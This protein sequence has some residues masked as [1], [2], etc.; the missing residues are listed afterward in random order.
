MTVD[1]IATDMKGSYE[2][3]CYETNNEKAPKINFVEIFGVKEEIWNAQIFAE[4]SRDH[5]KQD[6]P[7]KNKYYV[8]FQIVQ[9]ELYRKREEYL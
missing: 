6:H 2:P 4:A 3:G 5:S 7:A 1:D 9:Q 8:S